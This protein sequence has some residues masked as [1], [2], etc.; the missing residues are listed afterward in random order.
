AV[1]LDGP[2]KTQ[3]IKQAARNPKLFQELNPTYINAADGVIRGF[4][5]T[6]KGYS[7]EAA[8]A[9]IRAF[10][11]TV[12]FAKLDDPQVEPSE[13]G[14]AILPEEDGGGDGEGSS[15]DRNT[16]KFKTPPAANTIVD[17]V[18][19]KLSPSSKVEIVFT[20][21]KPTTQE[22]FDLMMQMLNIQKLAFP[23]AADLPKEPHWTDS[24]LYNPVPPKP[25][26]MKRDP[27]PTDDD[28][29]VSG[30]AKAVWHAK[31]ADFPI[32]VISPSKVGDDGR[33]YVH[34]KGSDT[35]VPLDEIK[36]ID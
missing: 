35:R 2:E 20:S 36:F 10:R 21:D 22:D 18:S 27:N 1:H 16:K 30:G 33:E 3:A 4:L 28:D 32:V 7:D 12:A 29:D 23:K 15:N 5:V 13:P 14:D 26:S 6:N 11:D 19:F 24:F 25:S 9:A 34:I 17:E 8:K 31:E